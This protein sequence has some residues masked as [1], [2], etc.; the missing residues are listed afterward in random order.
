MEYLDGE[1]LAQRLTRGAL[2]LDQALEY[3]WQI[4]RALAQA[5]SRGIVHRDLK[6][7]NIM[8][9]RS[10]AKLLDFGLARLRAPGVGIFA[11]AAGSLTGAETTPLTREG[12]LLG[13][14]QYMAPEQLAGKEAEP[15]TDIF[16]L[17][18][19]LY[20]M[21]TGRRP[22]DGDSAASVIAAV[23]P[24]RPAF[25]N[26]HRASHSNGLGPADTALFD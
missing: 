24:Y 22:F 16:A 19:V 1:T 7:G 14:L 5:H 2:P 18:V 6:P 20:E 23:L 4:A 11:A 12:T 15:A 17:G 25:R 3:A 10:G 13:T 26:E 8:L 9:T 21:I